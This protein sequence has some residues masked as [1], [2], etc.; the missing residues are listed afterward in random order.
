M[1]DNPSVIPHSKALAWIGIICTVLCTAISAL[2][3][4]WVAA[5]NSRTSQSS[6]QIQDLQVQLKDL[7]KAEA[8]I[9]W[10]AVGQANRED[11]VAGWSRNI[12]SDQNLFVALQTEEEKGHK[13]Y[14]YPTKKLGEGWRTTKRVWMQTPGTDYHLYVYALKESMIVPDQSSDL[15]SARTPLDHVVVTTSK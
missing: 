15:P 6:S 5:I 8:K 9:G 10:P 13:F 14:I 7:S 11:Y 3:T 1:D 4:V 2:C 12:P